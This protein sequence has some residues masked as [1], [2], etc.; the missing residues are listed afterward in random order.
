MNASIRTA[1]LI[2]I[3]WAALL[4]YVAG[5]GGG[6]EPGTGGDPGASPITLRSSGGYPGFTSSVEIEADGT[7][8]V[9]SEDFEGKRT[10]ETFA[11]PAD[12]LASIRAELDALDLGSLDPPLPADCCDLVYYEL[13]YEGETI[14]TD[15]STVPAELADVIEKINRLEPPRGEGRDPSAP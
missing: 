14:E 12:E 1:A 6:D 4:V 15:V 3:A 8:H 7:A 10:N 2:A 5:C 13:S 9:I 11:V